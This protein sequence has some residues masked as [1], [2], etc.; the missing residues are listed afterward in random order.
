MIIHRTDED[1]GDIKH[2][3]C[4]CK[5]HIELAIDKFVD[6]YEDAPDIV[7]LIETKFS[8]WEAPATCDMCDNIALYLVV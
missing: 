3:Y 1:T 6:D 8:E 2:M 7:D 4:V 5:E